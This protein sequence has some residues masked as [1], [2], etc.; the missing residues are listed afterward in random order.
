[1]DWLDYQ[2]FVVST[3][4]YDERFRLL[5]P[6]LGLAS[7]AGEVAGKLKK[8][9]RDEDGQIND[10]QRLRLIDELSDVL[11]YVTCCADDLSLSLHDL[12]VHNVE[13]LT[14]RVERNVIQGDGDNR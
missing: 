7:E 8:I 13:K 14:D 2:N 11:W 3:K 1:M 12:A 5:Y 6:V 9:F 4:R 10:E